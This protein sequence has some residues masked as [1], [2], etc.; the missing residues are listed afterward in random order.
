MLAIAIGVVCVLAGLA[1]LWWFKSGDKAKTQGWSLGVLIGTAEYLGERIGCNLEDEEGLQSFMQMYEEK[2]DNSELPESRELRRT[3]FDP[4]DESHPIGQ[5]HAQD[6]EQWRMAGI[7]MWY[8]MGSMRQ[9]VF[10]EE[11]KESLYRLYEVHKKPIA[12]LQ[13]EL[14]ERDPSARRKRRR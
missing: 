3:V 1:A 7:A 8:V 12:G 4:D 13:A 14:G 9:K 2:V 6:N 10:Q 11:L 5:R